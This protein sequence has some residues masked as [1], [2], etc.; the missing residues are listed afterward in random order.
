MSTRAVRGSK[1]N[2]ALIAVLAVACAVSGIAYLFYHFRQGLELKEPLNLLLIGMDRNILTEESRDDPKAMP[3][4]DVL[5]LSLIDP[6]ERKISM[7]SIPRDSLVDIPGRG[8]DR[9]NDASVIG[10]IPLTKRMVRRLTGCPVDRYVM[11]N[12]ESFQ[13]LVDLV[14]G[15]EIDVD[16]RMRLADQY[17][18]YK[19]R[20]DPGRQRLNGEQALQYV[21]FRNEPLGD[22][23]RVERQRRL[24]LALYQKLKDPAILAKA[25]ALIGLA[26]KH[27]KTDLSA[28]E[29]LTL[30][31][32]A[33]TIDPGKDINSYTLPGSFYKVYWRPDRVRINELIADLRPPATGEEN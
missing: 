12:F 16:K 8:V 18:E 31:N 17:G 3:R 23:S 26:R 28:R 30:L 21:R 7:V 19:I 2:P 13:Q 1:R 5:I 11:V 10:G 33:K 32:F 22:I 29:M 14:G 9:I 15:V 20:L 25:P 24:L 27:L 4:T 6:V